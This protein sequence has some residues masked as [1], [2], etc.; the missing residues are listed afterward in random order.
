V[1]YEIPF[2]SGGKKPEY[3]ARLAGTKWTFGV[4]DFLNEKPAFV[5]NGTGFYNTNDDPRQRFAYVQIK[6][7]L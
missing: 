1:T 3:A 4:L 6:K 2:G 7:S 5:T